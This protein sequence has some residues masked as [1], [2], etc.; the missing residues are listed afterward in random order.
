M[1]NVTKITVDGVEYEIQGDQGPAGTTFTPSV[2]EQGVI[3]WTNDGGK[4]NPAPVDIAA[5]VDGVFEVTVSGST[6][7]IT[8]ANNTRYM[9]GEVSTISITPPVS[10]TAEVIFTSGSTAAVLTLPN[11]VKMPDWW[12]GVEANRIYDII[13]TDGVYGAVMSWALV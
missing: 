7:V 2:S 11:T 3:S 8:G 4:E 1:A 5:A 6:P 10:G 9:C 12:T 13:I